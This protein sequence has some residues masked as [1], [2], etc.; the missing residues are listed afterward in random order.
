MFLDFS[1]EKNLCSPYAVMNGVWAV[2]VFLLN[3]AIA[4]SANEVKME[5]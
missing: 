1:S 3:G 4:K 5:P 2:W